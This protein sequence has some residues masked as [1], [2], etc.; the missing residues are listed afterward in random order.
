MQHCK[1]TK[2][3]KKPQ[4]NYTYGQI[5][6]Q[7]QAKNMFWSCFKNGSMDAHL[8]TTTNFQYMTFCSLLPQIDIVVKDLE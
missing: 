6:I 2:P 7:Y 8:S 5:L 1:L 4:T 3:T